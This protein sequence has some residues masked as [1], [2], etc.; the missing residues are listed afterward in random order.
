MHLG[1]RIGKFNADGS[2]NHIAGHN[3]PLTVTGLMLIIVGFWGFLMACVIIPGEAWSVG[4][5][6]YLSLH[7]G[8]YVQD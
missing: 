3:M 4:G 5:L 7:G 2:A 1:P 8:L 6:R